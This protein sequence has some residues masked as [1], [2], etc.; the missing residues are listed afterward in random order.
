MVFGEDGED[1]EESVMRGRGT[2]IGIE[3]EPIEGGM[4]K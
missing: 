2:A 4:V 1:S 3:T